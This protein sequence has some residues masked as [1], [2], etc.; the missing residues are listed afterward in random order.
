M[1][2]EITHNDITYHLTNFELKVGDEVFPASVGHLE[3]DKYIHT[4]I[5]LSKYFDGELMCGLPG[6][7]HTILDLNYSDDKPYQVRTDKGFGPIELYFKIGEI[8]N[9]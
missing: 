2:L 8:E 3:N 1:K 4:G 7:P 6:D 5:W 9:E